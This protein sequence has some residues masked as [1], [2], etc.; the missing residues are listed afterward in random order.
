MSGNLFSDLRDIPHFADPDAVFPDPFLSLNEHGEAAYPLIEWLLFDPARVAFIQAYVKGISPRSQSEHLPCFGA[1]PAELQS[2]VEQIAKSGLVPSSNTIRPS[3]VSA[4]LR[5]PEALI[6]LHCAIGASEDGYWQSYKNPESIEAIGGH[7]VVTWWKAYVRVPKPLIFSVAA[8]FFIVIL[9]LFYSTFTY[10][11]NAKQERLRAERLDQELAELQRRYL[12]ESVPPDPKQL[13]EEEL[14]RGREFTIRGSKDEPGLL[15]LHLSPSLGPPFYVRLD[16]AWDTSRSSVAETVYQYGYTPLTPVV[17]H[18]YPLPSAGERL[19][20]AK[21][22]YY[23][24]GEAMMKFQ[25]NQTIDVEV[26]LLLTPNGVQVAARNDSDRVL[27]SIVSP[28][29]DQTTVDSK[30]SLQIELQAPK[31]ARPAGQSDHVIHILTRPVDG[32]EAYQVQP[33]AIRV[34]AIEEFAGK[35]PVKFDTWISLP[36]SAESVK[37]EIAVVELPVRLLTSEVAFEIRE[38]RPVTRIVTV[39]PAQE[40]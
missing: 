7:P 38:A 11:H 19:I 34:E 30:F 40:P 24:S 20:N 10:A 36:P 3:Q 33:F 9:A 6:A 28:G 26:Q 17:S 5:T 18:S 22:T 32:S 12:A 4:I 1:V 2:V 15:A 16:V 8:S 14:R 37:Y 23:L 35:T 29:S 31:R 27:A 25:R 21:L 13:E 39:R